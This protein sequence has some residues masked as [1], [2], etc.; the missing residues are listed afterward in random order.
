MLDALQARLPAARIEIEDESRLHAGHAGAPRG[1]ESH[2]R[3]RIESAAF[4]GLSRIDR[5]RLVHDILR[6]ELAGGVHALALELSA[7][8]PEPAADP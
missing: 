7:P 8:E 1:G 5:H 3:I 6:D 2:Y 4:R